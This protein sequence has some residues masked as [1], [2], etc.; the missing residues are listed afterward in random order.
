[1]RMTWRVEQH[2]RFAEEQADLSEPVQDEVLAMAEAVGA[3]STVFE[4]QGRLELALRA[5]SL[6]ASL[7]GEDIQRR[8]RAERLRT[9][10]LSAR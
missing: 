8:A 2:P 10:W 6:A 5:A 3:R 7:D 9:R 1:M 4:S